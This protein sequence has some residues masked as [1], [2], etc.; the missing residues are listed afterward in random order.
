MRKQFALITSILFPFISLSVK[1]DAQETK[2][3]DSSFNGIPTVPVLNDNLSPQQDIN[4]QIDQDG[5]NLLPD[6]KIPIAIDLA[7]SSLN[8]NT[9][10]LIP[11]T[12]PRISIKSQKSKLTKTNSAVLS[13]SKKLQLSVQGLKKRLAK[14]NELTA[15]EA[16][17]NK[18]NP[19][20][21]E[22]VATGEMQF[23]GSLK[24]G[25]PL[26]SAISPGTQYRIAKTLNP[27]TA[28]LSD[29]YFEHF[30]P[31]YEL[32]AYD[33][34]QKA[35]ESN[36]NWY[37]RAI[38]NNPKAINELESRLAKNPI[39]YE[40]LLEEI[41]DAV[42]RHG[43]N[44]FKVDS[45]YRYGS[46]VWGPKNNPPSDMDLLVIVDGEASAESNS[47][48]D[49]FSAVDENDHR[50]FLVHWS[51]E[52]KIPR[53]LLPLNITMISRKY[54]ENYKGIGNRPKG[55][56]QTV[57]GDLSS[58]W[59]HGLLSYGTDTL[60]S[61][62]PS[63]LEI[64]NGAEM[65]QKNA[66]QFM[67]SFIFGD[68]LQNPRPIKH[69]QLGFSK[70]SIADQ[71]IIPK[72]YLRLLEVRLRLLAAL[73]RSNR[74]PLNESDSI[75]KNEQRAYSS[76]FMGES[77][78]NLPHVDKKMITATIQMYNGYAKME[79]LAKRSFATSKPHHYWALWFGLGL[80]LLA[81]MLF[82]Y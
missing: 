71:K 66:G 31:R 22:S 43:V 20:G 79:K 40:R 81:L 63:P 59:G 46:S 49:S 30:D 56:D 11:L 18:K 32:S 13:R 65:M 28:Q 9:A 44:V 50:S 25:A 70:E 62:N 75:L 52:N 23:D 26:L 21:E 78:P 64:I 29:S 67:E 16:Q 10:T 45:I 3:I 34:V 12:E 61:F 24:N 77:W 54:I 48:E 73:E 74:L 27:Y 47:E 17:K 58:D 7:P 15:S 39:P 68:G 80:G 6:E 51:D 69:L 36:R 82:F 5:N 41:K 57:L 37:F 4:S 72:I 33:A 1:L 8:Q 55:L 19:T 14:T 38:Q 53:G 35:A 2:E 60:A 42:H 76:Y